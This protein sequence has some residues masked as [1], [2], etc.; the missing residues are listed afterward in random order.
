MNSM[1]SQE[2]ELTFLKLFSVL[3]SPL[4]TPS[5]GKYTS[6]AR[7]QPEVESVKPRFEKI[8]ATKLQKQVYTYH[9]RQLCCEIQ[10]S[11]H[12][13]MSKFSKSVLAG[14][15]TLIFASNRWASLRY[16]C[17]AN[18]IYRAKLHGYQKAL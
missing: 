10:R 12:S 14:T 6:A 18:V 2:S 17:S 9:L 16:H 8:V 1:F 13:P 7:S 11:M 15:M 4:P 5:S 3:Q